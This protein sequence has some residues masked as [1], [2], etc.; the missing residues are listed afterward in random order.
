M[1]AQGDTSIFENIKNY[2]VSGKFS[3]AVAA[4]SFWGGITVMALAAESSLPL[5][6]AGLALFAGGL[7]IS[8]AYDKPEGEEE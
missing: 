2:R 3:T 4:V 5:C 8:G 1:K 6:F 7:W